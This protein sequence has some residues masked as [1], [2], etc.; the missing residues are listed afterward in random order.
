MNKNKAKNYNNKEKKEM[1]RILAGNR[2]RGKTG[3][4][5]VSIVI[6]NLRN[7]RLTIKYATYFYVRPKKHAKNK[8]ILVRK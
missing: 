4:L 2:T 3:F 6:S 8:C 5:S 7:L 1:L